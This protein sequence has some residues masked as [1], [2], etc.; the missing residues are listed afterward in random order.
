MCS[1]DTEA[2]KDT[3]TQRL[4]NSFSGVFFL[5]FNLAFVRFFPSFLIKMHGKRGNFCIFLLKIAEKEGKTDLPFNLAFV[6]TPGEHL[7]YYAFPILRQR[8][9]KAKIDTKVGLYLPNNRK[10]IV[11][12]NNNHVFSTDSV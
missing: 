2:T 3:F 7:F 12:R 4:R 11:E 10:R 8:I 6:T 1:F 9:D 5:P